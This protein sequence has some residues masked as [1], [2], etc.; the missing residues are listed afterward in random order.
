[1]A[2]DQLDKRRDLLS[3]ILVSDSVQVANIFHSQI[4]SSLA[5]RK[6][7]LVVKVVAD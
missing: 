7:E 4:R 2:V 3:L 1:M 6:P 5:K